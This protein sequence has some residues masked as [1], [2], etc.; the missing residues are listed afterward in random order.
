MEHSLCSTL[1]LIPINNNHELYSLVRGIPTKLQIIWEEIINVKKILNALTW[2]KRNNASYSH[3]ILP[4]DH[5]ELCLT[6]LKTSEF[7]TENNTEATL[8]NELES[9]NNLVEGTKNDVEIALED[10]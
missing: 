10:Q 3:F 7:Q 2:L 6:K 1:L 8:D 4:N 5:N 9:L